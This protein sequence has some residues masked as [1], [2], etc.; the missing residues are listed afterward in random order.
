MGELD[1]VECWD[2]LRAFKATA[3][4]RLETLPW[5]WSEPL[6]DRVEGKTLELRNRELDGA[7]AAACQRD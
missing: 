3:R 7:F 2:S 1:A 4:E 6:W 5:S